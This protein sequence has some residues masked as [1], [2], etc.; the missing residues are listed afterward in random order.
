VRLPAGYGVAD[1]PTQPRSAMA[2]VLII[3]GGIT[4]LATAYFLQQRAAEAGDTLEL[5]I[6]EADEQFGGKVQ[7]EQRDGFLIEGGPDSFVTY[8][9]WGLR[10]ARELGLEDQLI[11][12]NQ[13]GNVYVYWQRR[14]VP[15]MKGFR[16]AAAT[17]TMA[18]LNSPMFNI[19][20]K[21]R[22]LMEPWQGAKQDDED[23]SIGDFVRRRAGREC[24]HKLAGPL[25]SGIYVGDPEKLSVQAC[26]PQLVKL[27][28]EHGSLVRGYNAQAAQRQ[29]D[30]GSAFPTMFASLRG[31]TGQLVEAILGKLQA[32]LCPGHRATDLGHTEAGHLAV[33][34]ETATGTAS[35]EAD[36]VVLAAPAFAAAELLREGMPPLAERLERIP[37]VSSGTVTMAFRDSD[38]RK[39][40]V[41]D[42]IGIV[43]P[44]SANRRILAITWC[45]NKFDYR[46]PPGHTLVRVFIGGPEYGDDVFESDETILLMAREEL[47]HIAGLWASPVQTAIYRWPY[48]NPQYHVGHL[49][50][51][52]EIESHAAEVP[53]LFLTGSAYRGIGIPDCVDQ[54]NRTA[55]RIGKH[56]AWTRTKP[57]WER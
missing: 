53:G 21:L 46:A 22:M 16:L 26:F 19:R 54:A 41:R 15:I 28:K 32:R 29:S 25:M 17:N 31:G 47:R 14:L 56:F 40:R 27:E 3:G 9:P 10:L 12:N 2:R 38:L 48:G 36:A 11:S 4:G 49:E 18:L 43:I 20:A 51:V 34:A 7:T 6:L 8:K 55:D 5:T 1:S 57:A 37:Y 35:F 23:E 52:D 50:L 45:N 30:K 13:S 44:Q 42:G 24:L 33:D 39:Q